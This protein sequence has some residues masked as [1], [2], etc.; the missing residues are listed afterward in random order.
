MSSQDVIKSTAKKLKYYMEVKRLEDAFDLSGADKPQRHYPTLKPRPTLQYDGLH[1]RALKHYFR[2]PEVKKHLN[3]MNPRPSR[4]ER[5]SK[6]RKDV[7]NYMAK[8]K[9]TAP[10][11]TLVKPR[12]S[13]KKRKNTFRGGPLLMRSRHGP[14]LSKGETERLV[15]AATRLLVASET[16]PLESKRSKTSKSRAAQSLPIYRSPSGNELPRI[17]STSTSTQMVPHRPDRPKSNYGMRTSSPSRPKS[18][19]VGRPKSAGGRLKSIDPSSTRY[20]YDMY[21]QRVKLHKQEPRHYSSSESENED[22]DEESVDNGMTNILVPVSGSRGHQ[23]PEWLNI[24]MSKVEVDDGIDSDEEDPREEDSNADAASVSQEDPNL[25]SMDMCT[26]T[27]REICTQT[28]EKPDNTQVTQ[29]RRG[30]DEECMTDPYQADMAIQTKP[31]PITLSTQ[32]YDPPPTISTQTIPPPPTMSTQTYPEMSTQTTP[33]DN[34]ETQTEIITPSIGIQCTPPDP[35]H[36]IGIQ[37]EPAK[38]PPEIGI[39]C[40]PPKPPLEISTQTIHA[41]PGISTQYDAPSPPP[42]TAPSSSQTRAPFVNYD[43]LKHGPKLKSGK[44]T[45]YELAIHT[46]DLLGAGTKADIHITLYGERGNTGKIKL[47]QTDELDVRRMK[48]QKGQIDVFKVESYNVGKLECISVGHNRNDIGCGWYLAKVMVN[49]FGNNITYEFTCDRWMSA[50]NEDGRTVRT[51]PVTN[52]IMDVDDLDDD[53]YVEQSPD[54]SDYSDNDVHLAQ[55]PD[56]HFVALVPSER[57]SQ[58]SGRSRPS[59]RSREPE[60]SSSESESEDEEEDSE[61]DRSDSDDDD[62]SGSGSG[63]G[64]SSGSSSGSGSDSGSSGSGSDSGDDRKAD[65]DSRGGRSSHGSRY[66]DRSGHKDTPDGAAAPPVH[67]EPLTPKLDSTTEPSITTSSSQVTSS[68][69]SLSSSSGDSET[70][71]ESRSERTSKGSDRKDRKE[72]SA[73][74]KQDYM[75]GFKAAMKANQEEQMKT[76]EREEEERRKKEEEEERQR[77]AEERLLQGPSIHECCKDGNLDRV[78]VL[79]Q[80]NA[81]LKHTPDERGWTPLHISSARGRL[82]IVRWLAANDTKLEDLTPTGYTALHMAAMNGHLNVIMVLAAMGSELSSKTVDE[83][84]PLHLA[85]MS[86][87]TECCKWLVGN[88]APLDA[89]DNMGRTAQDLAEEYQHEEVEAFL[90]SCRKELTR[91]DSS[92]AQL[93]SSLGMSDLHQGEKMKKMWQTRMKRRTRDNSWFGRSLSMSSRRE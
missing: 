14:Y 20:G 66:K 90:K 16:V 69:T 83:Q 45:I 81:K 18:A 62:D 5:E 86:G 38:P 42:S 35:P 73:K 92:L 24:Q 34:M 46:G 79:V 26:Q 50:Q 27:G 11:S 89:I 22:Y 70:A 55:T 57:A 4:N 3:N 82:D 53:D 2:N 58:A 28:V 49:E 44:R 84:T 48:F 31:P 59:R 1:D 47:K 74:A 87:H 91:S 23:T 41:S 32:T 12:S 25:Y 75:A 71:T 8:S 85:S 19:L 78:K 7:D 67:S 15:N 61:S 68:A 39:Q 33:V 88:R 43:Y 13:P 37:C 10:Y 40:E 29:T 54:S 30:D 64:S 9:F 21:G 65:G 63:S 77:Q 36:E 76:K 56:G 17:M 6:I 93:R 60:S 51:L 52:V 72:N 80:H